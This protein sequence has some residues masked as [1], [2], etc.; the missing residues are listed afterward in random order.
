MKNES[1]KYLQQAYELFIKARSITDEAKN[2][3]DMFEIRLKISKCLEL[4]S[5]RYLES[6]LAALA[7]L[8]LVNKIHPVKFND[9]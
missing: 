8:Y 5:D 3:E 6:Q 1:K 4:F 2:F 9:E 7:C